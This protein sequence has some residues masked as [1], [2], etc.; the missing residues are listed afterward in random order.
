MFP[1]V[2][3]VPDICL[4]GD[5]FMRVCGYR[6]RQVWIFASV[7]SDFVPERVPRGCDSFAAHSK[8]FSKHG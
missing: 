7:F 4:Y 1:E 8:F 5:R 2:S 3:G 6:Q